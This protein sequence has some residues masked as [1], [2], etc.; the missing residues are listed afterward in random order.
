VN[1]IEI[2]PRG[3]VWG[4]VTLRLA[5]AY[6]RLVGHDFVAQYLERYA[7]GMESRAF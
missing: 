7:A 1:G 5:D 4:P 2:G 6:K 3:Q